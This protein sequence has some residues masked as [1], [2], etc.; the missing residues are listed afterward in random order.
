MELDGCSSGEVMYAEM[1]LALTSLV[2]DSQPE[3]LE[4]L[5]CYSLFFVGLTLAMMP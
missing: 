4:S 1:P 2:N 5:F 3:H